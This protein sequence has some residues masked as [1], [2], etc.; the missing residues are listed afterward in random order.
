MKFHTT[1]VHIYGTFVVVMV[2]IVYCH[3]GCSSCR[4]CSFNFAMYALISGMLL[5]S[6]LLSASVIGKA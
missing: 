4:E 1:I 6:G 2:V 5:A 3:K